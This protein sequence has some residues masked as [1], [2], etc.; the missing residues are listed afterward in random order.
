MKKVL[1][2]MVTSRFVI[3]VI[4]VAHSS[5]MFFKCF[6]IF[7]NIGNTKLKTVLIYR[8]IMVT[9]RFCM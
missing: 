7:Q 2:I 3:T 4:N 5:W 8:L 1:I 9:S 6:Q